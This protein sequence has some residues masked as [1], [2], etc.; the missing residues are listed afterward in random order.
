MKKFLLSLSMFAGLAFYASAQTQMLADTSMEVTGGGGSDWSSTST[1]FGTVLC[2]ANCGTCGGPCA[3]RSG[4][5]YAWF[6]GAGAAEV[7]TLTQTFN[8]ATAGG[9]SLSFWLM[10]PNFGAA[11]DSLSLTLDGTLIWSKLGTDSAGFESTYKKVTVP[12]GSVS[13]GS[14]TLSW[15]GVESGTGAG[16]FNIL[17]DDISLV[18]GGSAG[19]SEF[20]FTN[21]V[22]VYTNNEAHIL[23]LA[24]N[25]MEATDLG[26]QISD[27]SGRVLR[28]TQL[29][30]IKNDHITYNTYG[31]AT[32]VYNVTISKP[33]Y[34]FSKKVYI[35]E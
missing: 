21:G 7:G 3:P 10:L 22:T 20:D 32:G 33:G 29:E 24:F 11:V 9:G 31:F 13:A 34:A 14:H 8:V 6:G 17:V 25:F 28:T 19:I 30:D 1:N 16:T 27:M 4:S 12:V 18:V 23:N 2:D 5:W 35:Q 15:R 26:I